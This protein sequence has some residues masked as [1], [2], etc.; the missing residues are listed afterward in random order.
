MSFLLGFEDP[1][2]EIEK[3]CLYMSW[4]STAAGGL[5][6]LAILCR[7]VASRRGPVGEGQCL[8]DKALTKS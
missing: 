3:A 7:T 1:Q 2:V 4:T 8:E 5:C 6:L